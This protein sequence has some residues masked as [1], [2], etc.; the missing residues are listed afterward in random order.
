MND[1]ADRK[2][3]GASA[4]LI[5]AGEWRKCQLKEITPSTAVVETEGGVEVGETVVACVTELGALPGVVDAADGQQLSIT[6]TR[7]DDAGDAGSP[8]CQSAGYKRLH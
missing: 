2:L 7:P 1:G 3:E 4:R 5:V 6:F 8:P